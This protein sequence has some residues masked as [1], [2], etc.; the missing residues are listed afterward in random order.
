[1]P[2]HSF[3]TCA[4]D[5]V[6]CAEGDFGDAKAAK[7]LDEEDHDFL[8]FFTSNEM[9]STQS[10][11]LSRCSAPADS[12][13]A[14]PDRCGSPRRQ[15]RARSSRHGLAETAA[16]ADAFNFHAGVQQLAAA[17][18]TKSGLNGFEGL[19]RIELESSGAS[20]E[21]TLAYELLASDNA[22][23]YT[24]EV[25]SPSPTPCVCVNVV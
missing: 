5:D 14:S 20:E 13:F 3:S 21:E 7:Q 19:N 16:K 24:L 9:E 15:K 12:S 17:T 6:S 25:R 4:F 22:R 2:P 10:I 11:G 23:Q 1:M 8:D 18:L